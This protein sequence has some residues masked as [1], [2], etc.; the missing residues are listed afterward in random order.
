[1]ASEVKSLAQQTARATE[2]I[3]AQ[4][5]QVQSATNDAVEA[6]RGITVT[7]EGV[8]GVAAAIA[9]AVEQQGAATAEIARNVQQVALST[10]EVTNTITAVRSVAEEAGAA[11]TQVLG[12]ANDISRQA[13][14]LNE[15]VEHFLG[16]LKAA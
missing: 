10:Q 4:I 13:G 3:G 14:R 8:S 2:E 1:V 6:I 11:V 12:N 16:G 7:I 5:A 15:E 9:A